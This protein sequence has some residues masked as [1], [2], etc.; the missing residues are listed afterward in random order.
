MSTPSVHE[1]QVHSAIAENTR[2]LAEILR[3]VPGVD[4]DTLVPCTE[5]ERQRCPLLAAYSPSTVDQALFD[6]RAQVRRLQHA[7]GLAQAL[8][9][10]DYELT[11]AL[12]RYGEQHEAPA[13]SVT[14]ARVPRQGR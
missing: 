9:A 11:D 14:G 7:L 5:S 3:L 6:V 10:R 2:L 1:Q 4:P 12:G 13:T 8:G